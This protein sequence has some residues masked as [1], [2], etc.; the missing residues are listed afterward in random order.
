MEEF[1]V[2]FPKS[3]KPA[4]VGAYEVRRKPNGQ[5]VVRWYAWWN[6]K[7]WGLTAQTPEG[8]RSCKDK[9]SMEARRG[10]GFEWRG[11]AKP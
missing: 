7:F 2:W 4:R 8:A 9:P 11:R 5:Q 10:G 1:S 6:G 3:I